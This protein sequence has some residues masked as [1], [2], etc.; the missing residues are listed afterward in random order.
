M[1]TY[2]SLV[3]LT[4]TILIFLT[5][6]YT[7]IVLHRILKITIRQIRGSDRIQ[8]SL[9]CTCFPVYLVYFCGAHITMYR[10]CCECVWFRHRKR[11]RQMSWNLWWKG[12]MKKLHNSRVIWNSWKRKLYSSQSKCILSIFKFGH[13][14]C[15][16]HI[17]ATVISSC[18]CISCSHEHMMI[19]MKCSSWYLTKQILLWELIHLF[20]IIVMNIISLKL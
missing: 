15:E 17:L 19:Y 10:I 13:C 11:N 5:S 6:M 9:S 20:K 4:L 7:I 12:R 18:I 14:V 8:L 3:I 16:E 1:E 2:C